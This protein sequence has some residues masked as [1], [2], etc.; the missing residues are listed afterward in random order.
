M[1]KLRALFGSLLIMVSCWSC[2]AAI[3]AP[4][5]GWWWNPAESG[6]GFFIESQNGVTFLGAYFYDTDGHA[7]WLVAG[8]ANADSYNYT[9]PL[10]SMSGGQTLFG[11]Y[12][13]PVGPNNVG[14]VDLHLSDD[15]HGTLTWPGGTVPIERQIFGGTGAAFQP[16]SG[17]W[18]NADESGSGYS[19]ELQGSQL[20][21]VGFMY[22]DAGREVWYFSA[23]PMSS[24]TTYSGT[25]VQFAN[26]QTMGGPYQPPGV[27]T[28]I[29]T[30]DVV[31]DSTKSATFTFT[32]APVIVAN[33]LGPAKTPSSRTSK[34]TKEFLDDLQPLPPPLFPT[35]FNGGLSI[36][37]NFNYALDGLTDSGKLSIR[38]K[39]VVWQVPEGSLPVPG[40]QTYWISSADAELS[41]YDVE[42]DGDGTTCTGTGSTNGRLQDIYGGDYLGNGGPGRLTVSSS[43]DVDFFIEIFGQALQFQA[44]VICISSDG[45]ST[46]KEVVVQPNAIFSVHTMTAGSLIDGDGTLPVPAPPPF[47]I[48]VNYDFSFSGFP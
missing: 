42:D 2:N 36:D 37:E 3:A 43:G 4:Q 18:W 34:V 46:T 40:K 7:E 11:S 35:T 45:L 28:T 14:T 6:R 29:A 16:S 39:N 41:S 30:L 12:V 47:I 5:V 31:F 9:G 19:V 15:T 1:S 26:G 21:I 22:D 44:T 13:A 23:G 48:V 10:Y 24:D 20:F 27:P 17:W 38:L 8:G 32:E 25:V 33:G